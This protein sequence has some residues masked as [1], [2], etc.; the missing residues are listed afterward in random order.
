MFPIIDASVNATT[1]LP[2]LK[3]SG[4][5]TIIRYYNRD[6]TR[7]VIKRPEVNAILAAG[8]SLCI[9]H[10]RGGRDPNE[11]GARNGRLDAEHCRT[12]GKEM[13]QPSGSAVYFA[14]D[15]DISRA[16]LIRMVVPYFEAVRA[17]M[18]AAGDTPSFR[19]GAYG[20]G[21]TCST[22]LDRGL[23]DFTWLSQSRG[24]RGTPEF[25]ASNRWS[26]VQMMPET[27]CGIGVDPDMANPAFPD[28][29]QFGVGRVGSPEGLAARSRRFRVIAR[30]LRLRSGP[31]TNFDVVGSLAFGQVVS[32]TERD[33][34]WL[35]IDLQ[36]DGGID[37]AAH[38]DFLEPV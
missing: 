30:G 21:L 17:V 37:G 3:T 23:A 11:Y 27:L 33:G 12:Y 25:R 1:A 16:D 8:L 26:L 15:F 10:Q 7:K 34:D 6:M 35:L 14:V 31:G 22:L 19:V 13:G 5:G 4:I 24:F 9:V 38:R 36:G 32:A 18:A 20:S 2:C 29:G 28:F